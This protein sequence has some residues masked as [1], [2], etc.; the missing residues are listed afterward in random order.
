MPESTI[1]I[2]CDIGGTFTDIVLWDSLGG[3]LILDKILTTPNDPSH[4][5]LEGVERVLKATAISAQ[6][7][8]GADRRL[9]LG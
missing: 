6:D 5:V 3:Q 2:G 1:H 9:G 7:L 8:P 4:A